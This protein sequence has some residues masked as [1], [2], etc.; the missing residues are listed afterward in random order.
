MK[1]I[2]PLLVSVRPDPAILK[3]SSPSVT[4]ILLFALQ[5]PRRLYVLLLAYACNVNGMPATNVVGASRAI[6]APVSEL[7][8]D[9]RMRTFVGGRFC[10]GEL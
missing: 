10:S 5:T 6:S 1:T 2:A 8:R 7:A 3:L 4:L 9:G